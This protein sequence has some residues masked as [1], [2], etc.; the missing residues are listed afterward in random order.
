MNIKV[1]S[2][3][4]SLCIYLTVNLAYTQVYFYLDQLNLILRNIYVSKWKLYFVLLF[5]FLLNIMSV[6]NLPFVS[7]QPDWEEVVEEV[8]AKTTLDSSFWIACY[9]TG[10]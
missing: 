5:S 1:S 7:V 9:L 3:I 10:S 6:E 8:A 2:A 4:N